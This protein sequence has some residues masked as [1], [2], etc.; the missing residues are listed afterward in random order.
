MRANVWNVIVIWRIN[1]WNKCRTVSTPCVDDHQSTKDDFHIVG[2][3]AGVCVC[4]Q[5]AFKC[6]YLERIGRPDI[7]GT[8]SA[9]ARAGTNCN[10]ACD[11]DT[12]KLSQM[13]FR[14]FAILWCWRQSQ[15]MQARFVPRR[16]FCGRFERFKVDI[17]WK[18]VYFW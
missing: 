18:V 14:S 11:G 7:W 17:W 15:S 13:H 8:G 16:R 9:L 12:A 5:I 3:L 4:A 1:P 6:F 2:E 10:R